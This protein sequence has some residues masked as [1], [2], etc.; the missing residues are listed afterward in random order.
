MACSLGIAVG[1]LSLFRWPIQS[2]RLAPATPPHLALVPRAGAPDGR[3]A[4]RP[5]NK[6]LG[7]VCIGVFT[8]G[9]DG[10]GCVGWMGGWVAY[11]VQGAG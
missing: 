1:R 11:G 10:V 5:D 2:L 6:K 3:S 8:L 4:R 7:Q 9:R